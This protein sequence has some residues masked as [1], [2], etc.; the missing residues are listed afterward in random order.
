V[1]ELVSEG[2]ASRHGIRKGDCI[3]SVNRLSL[4][5][6]STAEALTV[7]K[8]AG[9]HVTLVINRV[10]ENQSSTSHNPSLDE[11]KQS[12][13]IGTNGAALESNRERKSSEALERAWVY[14]GDSH[15]LLSKPTSVC[16]GPSSVES[17]RMSLQWSV[18]D[19]EG[20]TP[21]KRKKSVHG[22]KFNTRNSKGELLTFTDSKSTLPRKL[23]G[24]KVGVYLVELYKSIGGWLGIQLTG[25]K[26][27]PPTTPIAIRAVLK[28]GVAHKSGLISEKDEIIEVNGVSFE[29]LTLRE[30]VQYIRD[31]PPGSISMI[32]R[33]HRK[34]RDLDSCRKRLF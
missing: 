28:G 29:D 14:Q 20:V 6:L 22:T 2:V 33:D 1:K 3:L 5:G 34:K 30:A 23:S 18:G 12:T 8:K 21:H 16:M 27:H 7:L 15:N 10:A 19:L 25:S 4:S 17:W 32:M 13:D 24:S 9:N 11:S 31:L 26:D